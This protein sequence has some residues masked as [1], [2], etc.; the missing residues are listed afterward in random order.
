MRGEDDNRRT[1]SPE[2]KPRGKYLAVDPREKA[3]LMFSKK[4]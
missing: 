1:P 4:I 3:G 2:P